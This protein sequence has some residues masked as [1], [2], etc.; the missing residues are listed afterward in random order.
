MAQWRDG[1]MVRWC[2]FDNEQAGWQAGIS[3]RRTTQRVDL[4]LESGG[5]MPGCHKSVFLC[6]GA[7]NIPL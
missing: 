4:S 3:T 7:C 5:E 6:L 1:A 2:G